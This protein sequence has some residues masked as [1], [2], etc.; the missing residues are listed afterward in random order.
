MTAD[1][2]DGMLPESDK[3]SPVGRALAQVATW[4]AKVPLPEWFDAL[5][6][7]L[8]VLAW[9]LGA[10]FLADS[11]SRRDLQEAQGV[12]RGVWPE[13]GPGISPL[14]I[15]LSPLY[16]LLLAPLLLVPD[17]WGLSVAF[18]GAQVCS[19][20]LVRRLARMVSGR[21][22]AMFAA[23]FYA[24]ASSTTWSALALTHS[25]LAPPFGLAALLAMDRAVRRRSGGWFLAAVALASVAMQLHFLW[26]LLLGAVLLHGVLARL[27]LGIAWGLAGWVLFVASWMPF[28]SPPGNLNLSARFI[29]FQLARSTL[30]P[31]T[32]AA[33]VAACRGSVPT[34][35]WRNTLLLLA[36][37]F[38]LQLLS[39]PTQE[40]LS[41]RF[42]DRVLRWTPSGAPAG[43]VTPAS[44]LGVIKVT[45]LDGRLGA[46]G[47]PEPWIVVVL[48]AVVLGIFKLLPSRHS[49]M[50]IAGTYSL[51]TTGC[52]LLLSPLVLRDGAA[53]M[54]R[55]LAPI[56]PV[57][58]LA[59][60]LGAQRLGRIL[61]QQ[62]DRLPRREVALRVSL[63]LICLSICRFAMSDRAWARPLIPFAA[64]IP[65]GPSAGPLA[66]LG[67]ATSVSVP[68]VTPPA[69]LSGLVTARN[70]ISSLT[71]DE[72]AISLDHVHG[73][74]AVS[75]VGG[76]DAGAW[77]LFQPSAGPLT[78]PRHWRIDAASDRPESGS[79]SFA[80]Q[81]VLIPYLPALRSDEAL[82]RS[83]SGRTL[84]IPLPL[85]DARAVLPHEQP[86]SPWARYIADGQIELPREPPADPR[87]D[88]VCV[89]HLPVEGS[90]RGAN[91]CAIDASLDGVT[92][93]K[94][95]S[96]PGWSAFRVG[97]QDKTTRLAVRFRRCSP[98]SV[99]IYD[100][101]LPRS[102]TQSGAWLTS[103]SNASP[104]STA[105][106]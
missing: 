89:L 29:A 72:P 12:L 47:A 10:D 69:Q 27:E 7:G 80:G 86:A 44:V 102:D 101:P 45:I 87:Y 64:A 6:L 77:L 18:A 96:G 79:R 40:L 90:S 38:T 56:A 13:V 36:G 76:R 66:L 21:T 104:K 95:R 17:G 4:L 92:L 70:L 65:A 26:G 9:W 46:L 62:L 53:F 5:A 52:A 91:D 55:Y 15:F 63:L 73:G 59:F 49:P 42:F 85:H 68:P 23:T 1:H 31:P 84:R 3:S 50:T 35:R 51:T 58:S 43:A 2:P 60:V 19:V 30:I 82:Y 74:D 98:T 94:T 39:L 93:T 81:F 67:L 100:V 78:D 11:D 25:A 24:T 99:D 71:S 33:F 75:L 41:P 16:F 14:N 61:G 48:A 97:P 105:E 34:R 106:E 83:N 32:L 8:L 103:C 28:T 54:P 88:H 22:T 20:L 37:L 57:L